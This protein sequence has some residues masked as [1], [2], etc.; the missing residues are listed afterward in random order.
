[1]NRSPA[2]IE[3]A[4]KAP[5]AA[6]EE[7]DSALRA[8][9][10]PPAA[11]YPDAAPGEM[12]SGWRRF[13]TLPALTPRR[14]QWLFASFGGVA[15]MLLVLLISALLGD[16][17]KP[18]QAARNLPSAK[19]LAITPG[20]EV[21]DREAWMGAA[22]KDVADIKARDDERGRQMEAITRQL[23]E[24]QARASGAAAATG[25]GAAASPVT[26]PTAPNAAAA[27][28]AGAQA[29]A[30]TAAPAAGQ[31]AS[32]A[33]FPRQPGAGPGA[34]P[35]NQWGYPPGSP[36]ATPVAGGGAPPKFKDP[37]PGMVRVTLGAAADGAG[38][39]ESAAKRGDPSGAGAKDE[40]RSTETYL[41]INFTPARLL[42]GMLAPT[43]DVGKTDPLPGLVEITD[44]SVLPNEVRA[45][46]DRA[47]VTVSGYGDIAS[48]RVYLR[49]N[50]ISYVRGDRQVAEEML[51]GKGCTA[52]GQDGMAGIK[53]NLVQK[54]GQI[55]ANALLAGIAGGIGKGFAGGSATVSVSPL[56]TTSA[57][58][59]N[60]IL[61]NGLG[62][63][64]G[65][66][67]DRLAQYYISQAEKILP[68][69]EI[70]PN[71]PVTLLFSKGLKLSVP[72]PAVASSDAP[73]RS[74][75][76]EVPRDALMRVLD[77]EE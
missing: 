71:Q 23:K 18:K 42:T 41:P 16:D 29:A 2:Q 3:A 70:F 9:V 34:T 20:Q 5:T 57:I 14:R 12:P 7:P 65:S 19:N 50:R 47:F 46:F 63:G 13:V 74:R 51:D 25:P 28:V 22:G 45:N 67:M 77:T 55:L 76:R 58:D 1:M 54:Q 26:A 32:A 24:L 66:A 35:S 17:T 62:Q 6:L 49:C 11:A 75:T 64:L 36:A 56:G 48:E 27:T 30:G 73:V 61:Q 8:A 43:A 37:G 39:G 40:T 21:N 38:K 15:L 10:S 4:R 72:P 31:A 53:G 59:A 60:K 44:L 33:T 69:I 52:Y 68:V